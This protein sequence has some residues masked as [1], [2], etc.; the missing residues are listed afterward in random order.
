MKNDRRTFIKI[1]AMAG[2]TAT[3][4]PLASSCAEAKSK[5]FLPD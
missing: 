2:S 4:L 3:I 1:A 5:I